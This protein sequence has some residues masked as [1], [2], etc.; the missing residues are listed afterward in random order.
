MIKRIFDDADVWAVS[1]V[2]GTL[3][4]F[5]GMVLTAGFYLVLR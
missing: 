3:G 5:T 4:A 1:I 2:V